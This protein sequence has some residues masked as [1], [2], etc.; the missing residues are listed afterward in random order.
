MNLLNVSSWLQHYSSCLD[1]CL[2][3]GSTVAAELGIRAMPTFLLYKD[4]KK[5]NEVVGADPKRV[6]AAV[7]T[8]L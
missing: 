3:K 1:M 2:R 7:Q 4:G 6:E 8:V 5:F